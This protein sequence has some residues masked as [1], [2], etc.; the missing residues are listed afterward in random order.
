MDVIFVLL[1]ALLVCIGMHPNWVLRECG[2]F[3]VLEGYGLPY[4]LQINFDALVTLF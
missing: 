3:L 4:V 2:C 1:D